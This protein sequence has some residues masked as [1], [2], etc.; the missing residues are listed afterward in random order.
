[1][2]KQSETEARSAEGEDAA[3][4]IDPPQ[5]TP[6]SHMEQLRH[7]LFGEQMREFRA[8]F[9]ELDERLSAELG[10]AREEQ[11]ASA[12]AL[13]ALIRGEI[14]RLGDEQ[15]RE[16]E[17]RQAANQSVLDQ[18]QALS[19]DLG[20]RLDALQAALSDESE[21]REASLASTA[22]ELTEAMDERIRALDGM[23]REE[24]DRLQEQKTGRDELARL[25]GELAA[26]LD[27]DLRGA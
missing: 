15:Q 9:D 13:G 17:A 2:A 11:Q 14:Q 24:G 25:F 3:P 22:S 27:P 4:T 20:A 6:E 8:R 26:R 7:L 12:D 23:L 1:M 21:A 18:V 19:R 10:R 16:H 5:P